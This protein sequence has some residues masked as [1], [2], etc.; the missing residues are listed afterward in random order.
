MPN[1]DLTSRRDFVWGAATAAYQIEG[2]ATED[3]R[4]ESVWDRFCATPGK[5]RNGDT[6]EVACDFYHRYPDDVALMRELGLDAF[7]FSIAWPRVLPGGPRPRE[8]GRPRLLRPPRRRAARA[9]GIKPFADALPLGHAAGARGRG[10]LAGARDRRGVRRVRR[11]RR[12]PARRSRHALDHAQR[13]VGRRLDRPRAG[14]STRPGRT[15][16]ADAI[17]AAHHLLLSHGWAV[18]GAARASRPARRSGSRSTSS[19]STPASDSPGDIAA[20]R[21]IDGK[22]NRWFLDPL[23]RG[24]Y[25]ADMLDATT[26]P[27]AERRPGGDLGADR[28]PRRQQLLPLRRRAERRRRRPAHRPRPR[29]ADDRHGLGGASRRPAHAAR[30]RRRA[31]TR[32]RAIY[33]TENGAAFGDVRGHDGARARPRA[34][35]VPRARTSTRS[36]RA[37]ADGA[38]VKGYFVWSLLDNFEWAYG[39]SKRF[40]HR[41]RRLPDARAR[42]EGQLLLVPRLHRGAGEHGSPHDRV[43]LMLYTVRDE[44]AADFEATLRAVARDRLRR[45]RALR[46][47][48]ARAAARCAAGSTSSASRSPARHAGLDAIEASLPAL[49]AE[50]ATARHAIASCSAGSTRRRSTPTHGPRVARSRRGA[51][52][53]GAGLRARLPQPLGRARAAR[54][55]APFLDPLR[56]AAVALARAR[57]RLGVGGGRRP[58]RPARARPRPRARSCT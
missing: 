1:D 39:Y 47:A 2:A 55:T 37:I 12:R 52:R 9:A 18:G 21:E 48:R 54:R 28:L 10:R 14:A 15:S 32:R 24:A 38:P 46:P 36:A 29:R 44:C 50:L 5:V 41:L 7:R 31:T 4:G 33:V 51:A 45:R 42:A 23:F 22:A 13:A 26:P 25:P 16:E 56:A 3:G 58:G 11:G 43:G 6:G 49:A 30:A 20:A 8:R 53:S 57:P 17:A 40:G 27:V 35:R 34:H 19:T